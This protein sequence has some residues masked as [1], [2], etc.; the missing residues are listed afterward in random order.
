MVTETVAEQQKLVLHHG[1]SLRPTIS[2]CRAWQ[3]LVG[4]ALYQ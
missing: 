1:V 3:A 2:S 4:V